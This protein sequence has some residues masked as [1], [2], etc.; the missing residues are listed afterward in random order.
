MSTSK[1]GLDQ[2]LLKAVD[3]LLERSAE[4]R[5]LPIIDPAE[6]RRIDATIERFE[7]RYA[8]FIAENEETA[9]MVEIA[10]GAILKFAALRADLNS[11]SEGRR[12]AN[13]RNN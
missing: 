5:L 11:K 1:P 12:P 13:Y 10:K 2:G 6:A 3:R 8:V 7:K 4:I 9:K